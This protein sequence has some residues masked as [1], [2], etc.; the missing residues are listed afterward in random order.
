MTNNRLTE[1]NYDRVINSLENVTKG[2]LH[3]F[4]FENLTIKE[5]IIRNFIAKS[6]SL[7]NSV[8]LLQ[9][10]KQFGESA[11]LY[12]VLVERFLYLK[13][14]ADN[15][16]YKEFDDWSFVKNFESRNNVRSFPEFNKN[17][18]EGFLKD[19]K[20][21]IVRYQKLKSSKNKWKEPNLEN[22]SKQIDLG[23]LYKL[24]YDVG[25]SFVHPRSSEGQ[26]DVNRL[27]GLQNNKE[28]TFI[29]ILHNSILI[30]LVIIKTSFIALKFENNKMIYTYCDKLLNY[31]S[32]EGKI[33]NLDSLT[34]ITIMGLIKK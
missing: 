6:F 21:E 11:V 16:L 22:Y 17:I 5:I 23:F 26:I 24:S 1:I 34:K 13:Y 20:T 10:T 15:N 3:S 33:S 32:E 9:Q 19:E 8:N 31:I 28:W 4:V 12:R 2:I 29:P 18:E 30:H 25:S 14:I 7:L 27:T